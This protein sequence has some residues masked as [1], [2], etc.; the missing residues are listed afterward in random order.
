MTHDTANQVLNAFQL[1]KLN[2]FVLSLVHNILHSTID[3]NSEGS[4]S[5]HDRLTILID[6]LKPALDEKTE[7]FQGAR[8]LSVQAELL[9]TIFQEIHHV[10]K[11]WVGFMESNDRFIRWEHFSKASI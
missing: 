7:V 2:H 1:S 9:S 6:L 10:C 11:E 3:V 5:L 8:L 4:E